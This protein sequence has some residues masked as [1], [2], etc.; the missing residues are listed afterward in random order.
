MLRLLGADARL[1]SSRHANIM[2]LHEEQ[3]FF[4]L[5]FLVVWTCG[6]HTRSSGG[7]P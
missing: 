4:L 1:V 5:V 2:W 3:L 7:V 6:G